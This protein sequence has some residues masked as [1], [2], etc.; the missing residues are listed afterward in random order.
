MPPHHRP[1]RHPTSRTGRTAVLW[2]LGIDKSNSFPYPIRPINSGGKGGTGMRQAAAARVYAKRL[3]IVDWETMSTAEHLEKDGGGSGGAASSVT[4][5]LHLLADAEEMSA[6][7][8]DDV[9]AP[10]PPSV[11]YAHLPPRAALRLLR[12][13]LAFPGAHIA[14]AAPRRLVVYLQVRP[15]HLIAAR[16]LTAMHSL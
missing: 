1:M 10:P 4:L 16:P 3:L 8:H 13:R 5:P 14:W 12:E 6:A 11:D 9:S 15:S 7:S 2:R